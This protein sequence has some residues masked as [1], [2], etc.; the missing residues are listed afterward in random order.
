MIMSRTG[1]SAEKEDCL[2][3]LQL[4]GSSS[5]SILLNTLVYMVGL[6]SSLRSGSEHCRLRFSPSQI[7]LVQ[8]PGSRSYLKYKEDVFKTNQGG[9]KGRRKKPKEVVHFANDANPTRCFVRLYKLYLEKCPT[10]RPPGA[11]YLQPLS[12]PK[13]VWFSKNPCGH[14][15][16]QKVVL[17]LMKK[18]WFYRLFHES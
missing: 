6:Y 10:D 18:C 7:E 4:L 17:G 15:T 5:L 2:W 1:H 8:E 3:E 13:D 11:F 16:L 12:K 14:N 9:L